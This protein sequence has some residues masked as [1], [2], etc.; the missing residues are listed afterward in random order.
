MTKNETMN[1]Q[2]L[3]I[4]SINWKDE[5]NNKVMDVVLKVEYLRIKGLTKY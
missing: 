1:D 4:F 5:G 2:Q 3:E